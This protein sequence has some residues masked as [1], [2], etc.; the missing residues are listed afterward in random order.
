[1]AKKKKR[2]TAPPPPVRKKPPRPVV[3][4]TGKPSAGKRPGSPAASTGSLKRMLVAGGLATAALVAVG[5]YVVLDQRSDAELR[6]A[7]TGGSCEVD[8]EADGKTTAS[9]HVPNPTYT[10][11]PPAGGDHNPSPA[12]GGVYAGTRVPAD[13]LLVHSMEH[14]YVV[15]WHQSDLPAEQKAELEAFELRNDGDV[16]VAERPALP[17]A[18]AATAWQQR[19]LCGAVEPAALDRFAAEYVGKGPEDVERG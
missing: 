7:L 15:V 11:E 19:L 18:V 9:G 13:G 10:V 16:I 12:R 1:M 2:P 8:T 17:V 14:G 4:S 5:G 3:T 6:E